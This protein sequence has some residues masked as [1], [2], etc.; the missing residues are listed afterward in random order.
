M[1]ARRRIL[2]D[3]TTGP[4]HLTM[5]R[6]GL[7][8]EDPCDVLVAALLQLAARVERRTAPWDKASEQPTSS[9][10]RLAAGRREIYLDVDVREADPLW[11]WTR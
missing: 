8:A 6:Y 1:N 2:P 9:A 7:N 3:H 10:Y 4:L 5:A 11:R